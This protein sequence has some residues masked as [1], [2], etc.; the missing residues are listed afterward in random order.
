MVFI[1]ISDDVSPITKV[2]LTSIKRSIEYQIK[3]EA[4]TTRT[5]IAAIN[6]S[7]DIQHILNNDTMINLPKTT[8]IDFIDFDEELKVDKELIKKFV[9]DL[10][11]TVK[12]LLYF[13][14]MIYV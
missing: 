4:K 7:E 6:S 3:E 13:I 14:I 12:F 9:S 5:L 10:N 11:F 2:D 8:L 1:S